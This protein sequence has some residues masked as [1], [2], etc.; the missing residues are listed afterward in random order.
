MLVILILVPG[1]ANRMDMLL[2][3]WERIAIQVV[4][5]IVDAHHSMA[6]YTQDLQGSQTLIG[7]MWNILY[8]G[9]N[10]CNAA[11]ARAVELVCQMI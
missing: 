2:L 11:I 9:L 1:L 3:K 8:N 5:P 6:F 7:Y 10:A 4:V